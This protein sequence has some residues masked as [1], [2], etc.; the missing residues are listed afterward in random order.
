M[1]LGALSGQ[2]KSV[3]RLSSLCMVATSQQTS[4]LLTSGTKSIPEAGKGGHWVSSASRRCGVWEGHSAA[5]RCSGA[6]HW[7]SG[8]CVPTPLPAFCASFW[9][10]VPTPEHPFSLEEEPL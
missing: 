8:G 9:D 10:A 5:F 4:A 1:L 6:N 2:K 3:S 7:A